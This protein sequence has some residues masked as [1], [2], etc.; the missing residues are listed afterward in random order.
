MEVLRCSVP[1]CLGIRGESLLSFPEKEENLT[2]SSQLKLDKD[3]R[4]L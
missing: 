3:I 1:V 2:K 4:D